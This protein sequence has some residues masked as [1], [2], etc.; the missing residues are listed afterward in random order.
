MTNFNLETEIQNK[1]QEENKWILNRNSK[2]S[3]ANQDYPKFE[4]LEVRKAQRVKNEGNAIKIRK[5][6]KFILPSLKEEAEKNFYYPNVIPDYDDY[7][8]HYSKLTKNFSS[9]V[10]HFFPVTSRA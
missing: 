9:F 1:R 8:K 3:E 5:A 6:K 2:E 7:N 4:Q 10:R